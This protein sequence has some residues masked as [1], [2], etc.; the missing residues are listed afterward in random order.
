MFTEDGEFLIRDSQCRT[1]IFKKNSPHACDLERYLNEIREDKGT[2][3]TGWRVCHD[4]ME[5]KTRCCRGFWN[6]HK[7]DFVAGRIVQ[8]LD[9]AKE[10]E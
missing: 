9:I 10:V 6:A 2:G 5:N 3:F 8:M 4:D 1:C 7:S